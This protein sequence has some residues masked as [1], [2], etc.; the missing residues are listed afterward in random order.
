[1]AAADS[2][3]ERHLAG[4]VR[5]ALGDTP[6]VMVVGPRQ[7]GKT[8]LCERIGGERASTV[9]SLDDLSVLAAAQAD[10]A[11]FV[12]S[13]GGL[14]IIDE[15]QRAPALLPAIKLAV[16]R[17]R[18]PGRFL[19]TGSANV[20]TLPKVSESLAGRMEIATLWT[21]SQDEIE[22]RRESFVDA[23]FGAAK[24]FRAAGAPEPR[25]HVLRRALL[26]GYPEVLGRTRPDRRHAWFSSYLTTI[27][28]R[29]VRDLANIDNVTAIPRLLSVLASRAGAMLNVADLSRTL[30]VPH[31]TLT[32]YLSLLEATFLV[33]LVPAWAAG[34]RVRALKAPRVFLTD[35]GLL[36]HLAGLDDERIS[37]DPTAAGPVLENF[38]AMELTRQIGWSRTRAALYHYRTYAGHEVDLALEAADGRIVGIEVKAGQVRDADFKGLR[39]FREV[40]GRRFCR[41]V[42]LSTG[43]EVLPFGENLWALP[44]SR[45]W[46]SHG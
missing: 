29:D 25:A 33:R 24:P 27:V 5:E 18:A 7:A 11:A 8:T 12:S 36:A 40:V 30:A 9:A 45:L 39:A 43:Q 35:T 21:L 41:G 16:D 1:M 3:L 10:P 15:V 13:P 22:R 42:V 26:G 37:A 17:R 38:V 32:R 19:L 2:L 14:L 23:V 20:L 4:Q 31:T 34:G 44:I 6:V 46:Q 28:Q